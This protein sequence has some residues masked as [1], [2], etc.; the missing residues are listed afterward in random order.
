MLFLAAICF[1]AGWTALPVVMEQDSKDEV[2]ITV[3][4][5][6]PR[7]RCDT[8]EAWF[9]G[10]AGCRRRTRF[11]GTGRGGAAGSATPTAISRSG[12]AKLRTSLV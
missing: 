10:K 11:G 4:P 8:P 3:C 1:L 12:G 7:C 9:R 5:G 6:E 2:L